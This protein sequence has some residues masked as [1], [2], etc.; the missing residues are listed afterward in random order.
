MKNVAYMEDDDF[1]HQGNLVDKIGIPKN[2]PVV[3]MIQAGWCPHCQRAKPAFQEFAHKFRDVVFCATI[4][5]D[6]QKPSE[7]K[8]GERLNVI[9]PNFRGFP[10]YVLYLNGKR[11]DK[12]IKGRSVR[13]LVEFVEI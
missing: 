9:K 5:T 1:D 4:E 12:E 11:V 3:M 2:Y 10:D 13:D 8:L 7:R 6:G